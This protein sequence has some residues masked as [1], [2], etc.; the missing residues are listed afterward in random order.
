MPLLAP[1]TFGD[2]QNEKQWPLINNFMFWNFIIRRHRVEVQ[3]CQPLENNFYDVLLFNSRRAGAERK[4]KCRW[5]QRASLI[6]SVTFSTEQVSRACE[7]QAR[8]KLPSLTHMESFQRVIICSFGF[9]W[10]TFI[11]RLVSPSL[12]FSLS[13]PAPRAY[14]VQYFSL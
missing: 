2:H 1:F 9:N 13:P 11:F 10:C 3:R 8:K 7:L 14:R 6:K 12:S 5:G 4:T